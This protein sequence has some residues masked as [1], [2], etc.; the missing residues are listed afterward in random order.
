[1]VLIMQFPQYESYRDSKTDF[2]DEIPSHWNI[3]RL[4]HLSE[5]ID[6]QPDHRAPPIAIENGF[7]YIGIRDVNKDGSLCFE[8]ARQVVEK[9]VIKQERSFSISEKDI[10]FGKVGTLGQPKHIKPH[11][12]FALSATL[13]LIKGRE[14]I[15]R[16]FL[17]YALDSDSIYRQIENCSYGATRPALGIQQIRKFEILL[18]PSKDQRRIA[19]FLD[20]KTA[21]IDEAIAK[22][23]KLISLLQEQKAILINRAVTK[24]LNPNVPMRD[25]G[26]EWIG[27]TPEDWELKR[28][29]YLF[30]QS[31]LPVR[32][33]DGIVTSYRD[34]EVTRKIKRPKK[35][36]KLSF[37]P[38]TIN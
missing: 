14:S 18:P 19:S 7:P 34:G 11:G 17:K 33:E 27:K 4:G 38:A 23:Q 22:K 5:V 35:K 13:V 30:T 6:P 28:A 12:R 21:E 24:G 32:K 3:A 36:N 20:Q 29:K 16:T 2:I 37:S 26:I 1:M 9:A 31:K 15:D 8:T 25:S 10:L